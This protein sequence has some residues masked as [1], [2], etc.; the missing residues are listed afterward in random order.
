MA[1]CGSFRFSGEKIAREQQQPGEK[2]EASD[3]QYPVHA[4]KANG[5]KHRRIHQQEGCSGAYK[6]TAEMR[7]RGGQRH[8]RRAAQAA[9]KNKDAATVACKL[10]GHVNVSVI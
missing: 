2:D 6:C 5:Q 7:R 3:P 4:D 10:L 9:G 1:A 8:A